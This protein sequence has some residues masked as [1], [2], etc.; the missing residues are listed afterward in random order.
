[1]AML[2]LGITPISFSPAGSSV[3]KGETL[4]DTVR[5]F[6]CLGVDGVV[7]RHYQKRLL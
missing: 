3:A 7:I 4:Y 6:E 2:K 5:T 1:M